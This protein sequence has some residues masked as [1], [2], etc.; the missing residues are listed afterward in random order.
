ML[1]YAAARLL[2]QIRYRLPSQVFRQTLYFKLARP[3]SLLLKMADSVL[4][5]GRESAFLIKYKLIIRFTN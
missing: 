4:K 1:I 3:L 5:L 2:D